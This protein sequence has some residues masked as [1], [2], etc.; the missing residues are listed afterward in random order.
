M[1]EL[2]GKRHRWIPILAGAAAL[3]VALPVWADEPAQQPVPLTS[4]VDEQAKQFVSEGNKAFR[5][6]RFA[7]AE[8]AYRKAFEVKP[9]YDIAGNMALAQLGQ[10]KYR[11]AAQNLAY[12]LRLFPVTGDPAA[13]KHMQASFEMAKEHVGGVQVKASVKDAQIFADGKPVGEAPLADPVFLEPGEH[14][15]EAKLEGYYDASQKVRVEKSATFDVTL[16]LMPMPKPEG[17]DE[18][19]LVTRKRSKIPAFILGGVAV[20][21]AGVGVTML[22]LEGSKQ[23]EMTDLATQLANNGQWCRRGSDGTITGSDVAGCQEV[24]DTATTADTF[25]N[26]GVGALVGAGALAAA[27]VGYLV[28]PQ[29]KVLQKKITTGIDIQATP[30]V[31]RGQ[32]GLVLW[33]SF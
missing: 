18:M 32:G 23:T 25:H 4:E 22:V 21:A 1:R 13:R 2:M 12:T 6:G 9:V 26:V 7:E 29:Q 3:S 28:W 30:V 16:N 31:G 10:E 20:A 11:E 19:E 8:A 33:G 27:A 17:G 15:I 14:T 24:Y 5:E